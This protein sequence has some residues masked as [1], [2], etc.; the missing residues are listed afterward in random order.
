MRLSDD[1]DDLPEVVECSKCWAAGPYLKFTECGAHHWYLHPFL[2]EDSLL[3]TETHE[4]R[5]ERFR[6]ATEVTYLDWEYANWGRKHIY[7]AWNKRCS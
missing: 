1:D 6:V 2:V 5:L 4:Q 7:R 3:L